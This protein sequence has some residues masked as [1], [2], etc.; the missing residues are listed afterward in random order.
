MH[1]CAKENF[2]YIRRV[3]DFLLNFDEVTM[4]QGFFYFGLPYDN[5]LPDYKGWRLTHFHRTFI[6]LNYYEFYF[7]TL[8]PLRILLLM[9][10]GENSPRYY[11][12]KWLFSVLTY[13]DNLITLD[14][15][16]AKDI[17]KE[18]NKEKYKE[19]IIHTLARYKVEPWC[20]LHCPKSVDSLVPQGM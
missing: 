9:W 18:L 3:E 12:F 8:K 6:P 17:F 7:S 5:S 20:P 15:L 4:N 10:D 11:T 19:E 16:L 2:D 1:S 14:E 13:E